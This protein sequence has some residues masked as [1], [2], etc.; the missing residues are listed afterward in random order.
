MIFG[1]FRIQKHQNELEINSKRVFSAPNV[2]PALAGFQRVHRL[3]DFI[4]SVTPTSSSSS[5]RANPKRERSGRSG[6]FLAI[7]TAQDEVCHE[8]KTCHTKIPK[9]YG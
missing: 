4:M 1:G 9:S 7:K 5:A 2:V 6:V 8:I 3:G